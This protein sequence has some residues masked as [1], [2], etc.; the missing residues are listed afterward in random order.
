MANQALQPTPQPPLRYGCGSAELVRWATTHYRYIKGVLVRVLYVV[1]AL[2]LSGC[3][4]F[5][6]YQTPFS[7]RNPLIYGQLADA[8]KEGGTTTY[9]AEKGQAFVDA[10]REA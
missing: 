1:L 4:L 2:A 5:P 3:G 10:Y 9:L 6:S 8:S 7:V